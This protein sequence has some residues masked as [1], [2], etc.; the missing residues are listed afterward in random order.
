MENEL[1]PLEAENQ[2][3]QGKPSEAGALEALGSHEQM[4]S[5]AYSAEPELEPKPAP[6][7]H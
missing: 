4:N 2:A 3:L 7:V 1:G 5:L 6:Q